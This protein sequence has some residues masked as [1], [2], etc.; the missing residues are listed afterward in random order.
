MKAAKQIVVALI[1]VMAIPALA[2]ANLPYKIFGKV[3]SMSKKADDFKSFT[4]CETG[5]C[6]GA[7][8]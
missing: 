3:S 7:G 5:C 2:L 8:K 1:A 6:I 4:N